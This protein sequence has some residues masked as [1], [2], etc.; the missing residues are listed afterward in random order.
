M[1]PDYQSHHVQDQ[2]LVVRDRAWIRNRVQELRR[3]RG[4]SRK[5]LAEAVAMNTRTVTFIGLER[6]EPGLSEAFALA[7]FFGLSIEE[8]F[9]REYPGEIP[10]TDRER[11]VLEVPHPAIENRYSRLQVLTWLLDSS[12]TTNRDMLLGLLR[13]F[14][15]EE[16]A[17]SDLKA[18]S[19]A[20]LIAEDPPISRTPSLLDRLLSR[21]SETRVPFHLTPAGRQAIMQ[22]YAHGA[23]EYERARHRYNIEPRYLRVLGQYPDSSPI[24]K[25]EDAIGYTGKRVIWETRHLQA[26]GLVSIEE[27]ENKRR[28]A[29]T[30]KGRERYAARYA[31]LPSF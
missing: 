30:D 24:R 5:E 23:G 10:Y 2:G 27:E 1:Q 31:N 18:L 8:V 11:V 14:E 6:Y 3:A 7:D 22:A 21:E 4:L 28:V 16:E 13:S 19:D 9:W 17:V 15:D 29:L 12:L 20:A 26:H 25:L